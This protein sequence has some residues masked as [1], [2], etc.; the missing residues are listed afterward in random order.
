MVGE[1]GLYH[2]R[3][4]GHSRIFG[5]HAPTFQDDLWTAIV[6]AAAKPCCGVRHVQIV[7]IKHERKELFAVFRV[8]SL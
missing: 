3:N 1:N 5:R 4:G 6:E 7:W 2:L 8:E